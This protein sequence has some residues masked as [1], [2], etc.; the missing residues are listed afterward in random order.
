M[1]WVVGHKGMLGRELGALLSRKKISWIGSD[2]EVDI[3]DHEQLSNF[4]ENKS[5]DCIINC[6]AYT[7]VDRAE[8][9]SNLAIEL[10]TKG[11][12]NIADLAASLNSRM[13][14]ISTDYVF[15]GESKRPWK[16]DDPVSPVN[17]YGRSKAD[18][19]KIVLA[20][21]TKVLIIRTS[22]LYGY[23]GN[24]FVK[25]MLKLMAEKEKI[26]VI[27]DQIGSPTNALDLAETI[28][29]IVGVDENKNGIYHFSNSGEI[30]WYDFACA[31]Q[32]KAL[33]TDLLK[34]KCQIQPISSD[35]YLVKAKRP[36]YSVLSK[37]KI[38]REFNITIS[39]WRESLGKFI[40]F[41]KNNNM[42]EKCN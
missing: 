29:R 32:E 12:G 11:P 25:T 28:I 2:R 6:A 4:A 42:T 8:N 14:H 37:E 39:D 18:G 3:R 34:R 26:E 17:I 21:W 27:V 5:I 19:E 36:L 24:N 15:N 41:L 30:S 1:I 13:V 7:A 33:K 16:E 22:W 9:E 23:Y 38:K 31:I 40:E 10:N 35:E 20:K